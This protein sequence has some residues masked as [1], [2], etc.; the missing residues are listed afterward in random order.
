MKPSMGSPTGLHLLTKV[1]TE[2]YQFRFRDQDEGAA[3][4]NIGA[5]I[6]SRKRRG[7]ETTKD[8]S[9][10]FQGH[11]GLAP[12]GIVDERWAES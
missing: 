1:T 11:V 5:Q 8:C 7:G 4:K 10:L 6:K 12:G 3:D 2:E 9:P